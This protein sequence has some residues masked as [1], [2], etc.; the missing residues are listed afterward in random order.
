MSTSIVEIPVEGLVDVKDFKVKE[1][2]NM[3]SKRCCDMCNNSLLSKLKHSVKLR[4][5]SEDNYTYWVNV[6]GWNHNVRLDE[7]CQI[8]TDLGASSLIYIVQDKTFCFVLETVPVRKSIVEGEPKEIPSYWK[9]FASKIQPRKLEVCRDPGTAE[10]T[11]A[12]DIAARLCCDFKC[13]EELK[14]VFKSVIENYRAFKRTAVILFENLFPTIDCIQLLH[15]GFPGDIS[16]QCE[17]L[18]LEISIEFDSKL[19][20]NR[21]E[22]HGDDQENRN[23]G[24]VHRHVVDG[25]VPDRKRIKSDE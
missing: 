6:S 11:M 17:K 21:L 16:F 22:S 3:L 7:I 9:E 14:I 5:D 25:T 8:A 23:D 24:S 20:R 15:V 13:G 1:V 10:Q 19:K 18:A 12:R 4:K 2:I